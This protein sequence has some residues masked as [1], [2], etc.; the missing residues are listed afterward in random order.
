[1][2]INMNRLDHFSI[3]INSTVTLYSFSSVS[4]TKSVQFEL[5]TYKTDSKKKQNKTHLLHDS[6]KSLSICCD[7]IDSNAIM[8][9]DIRRDSRR[10]C[11][12]DICW[13]LMR[14]ICHQLIGCSDEPFLLI[15]CF[16]WFFFFFEKNI[17][18][19]IFTPTEIYTREK[20]RN[21]NR[22]PKKKRSHTH[23]HLAKEKY[24]TATWLIRRFYCNWNK[25]NCEERR[26]KNTKIIGTGSALHA[27]T[28]STG[29]TAS[30]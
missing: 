3:E 28:S 20:S 7:P 1:M 24:K 18:F 10:Q 8:L 30:S 11:C 15:F 13:I 2:P 17:F 5:N 9:H 14:R 4:F 19:P 26:K 27:K 12:T 23:T 25:I 29:R 22:T 21:R 6:T 16:C